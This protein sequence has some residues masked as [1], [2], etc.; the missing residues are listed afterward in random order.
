M[1]LSVSLFR[2]FIPDYQRFA[3]NAFDSSKDSD[4][5]LCK[6]V[7][8]IV[9]RIIAI[10]ICLANG[11]WFLLGR[12]VDLSKSC[13]LNRVAAQYPQFSCS[14]EGKQA[15]DF[16][17]EQ[18]KKYSRELPILKPYDE[19]SEIP[20][21]RVNWYE[22]SAYLQPV[23]KEITLLTVL[24]N[25]VFRKKFLDVLKNNVED[26]WHQESVID[27]ADKCMKI[28]YAIGVLTLDDLESFNKKLVNGIFIIDTSKVRS[29]AKALVNQD[30]YQYRTFY[31][32][33]T[34]YHWIRGQVVY[35]PA[36]GDITYPEEKY[37]G[38]PFYI[39]GTKQNSWR[40][41]YNEYCQGIRLCA[42]EEELS[43]ED[44]RAVIWTQEDTQPKTF[45]LD[46]GTQPT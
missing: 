1:T 17:R 39:E 8:S 38:F 11:A 25:E 28:A 23:N 7:K 3:A 6:R 9:C 19:T 14:L 37:L 41:L 18:L 12:V 31:F 33:T 4:A 46:L 16:A 30:S 29:S 15:I 43:K 35:S 10:P 44:S 45:S 36:K 27:A 24:Y 42:S 13:F 20:V 5:D 32:C 40:I 34:I 21:W 22:C 2:N 26:P